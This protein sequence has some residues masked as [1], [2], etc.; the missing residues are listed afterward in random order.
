MSKRELIERN[1]GDERYIR[2]DETAH[3][4][5]RD[6]GR[7]FAKDVKAKA[8]SASKK[9]EGDKGDRKDM[10]HPRGRSYS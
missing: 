5:E 7:S 3:L 2:L 10:R 9:G 6:V 1:P 4:G 8:K